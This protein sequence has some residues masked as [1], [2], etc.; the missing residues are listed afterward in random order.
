MAERVSA[1]R[2]PTA[3]F[4]VG[5][6]PKSLMAILWHCGIALA[7]RER[8]HIVHADDLDRVHAL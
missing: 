5:G 6:V 2:K 1:K 4:D 7:M 8:L 3:F